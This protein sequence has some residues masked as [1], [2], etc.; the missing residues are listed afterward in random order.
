MDPHAS[1]PAEE[2]GCG[3]NMDALLSR[4]WMHTRHL[5]TKDALPVDLLLHSDTILMFHYGCPVGGPASAQ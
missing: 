2:P 4:M 5:V 1:R 3:V